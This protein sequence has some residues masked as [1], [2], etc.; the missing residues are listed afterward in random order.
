LEHN[1]W[2]WI[3]T[4]EMIDK[5]METWVSCHTMADVCMDDKSD[6]VVDFRFA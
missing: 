6:A 3:G 1:S 5:D 4:V 2:K